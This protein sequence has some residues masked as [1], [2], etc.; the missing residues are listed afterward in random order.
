MFTLY[1]DIVVVLGMGDRPLSSDLVV[2]CLTNTDADGIMLPPSIMEEMS[3]DPDQTQV[4]A[5]LKS[6]IFI[7]GACLL[8]QS[9]HSC[10]NK[11]RHHL[12]TRSL[13]GELAP[14][15]GDKLV[16]NGVPLG[17]FIGTTE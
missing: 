15:A 7:G 2:E 14:E 4:L 11:E 10:F 5:K 17:N 3:L 9:P 13:T 12:L 1:W 8:A 16:R 6:A